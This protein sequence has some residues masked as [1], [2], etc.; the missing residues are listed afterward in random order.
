MYIGTTKVQ[1]FDNEYVLDESG[2]T[3]KIVQVDSLKYSPGLL[4]I[5]VE[6]LSN[7]IDNVWRSNESGVKCTKIKVNINEETGESSVWNDGLWI[8]VELNEGT[9]M[10]NPELIFGNL[11]TSSNYD[12]DEE[13]LTSG[14]NGM[15]VKLTNVF[16]NE[17]YIEVY[18]PEKKMLYRQK[19]TNHMKDKGAHKLKE[20]EREEGGYTYVRWKPDFELFKCAKYSKEILG[21]FYKYV[22]DTAMI[23]GVDVYLNGKRIPVKNLGDYVKFY[24]VGSE[25]YFIS[26]RTCNVYITPSNSGQF[27][28]VAF[29][30]GVYNKDGGI[31]VQMWSDAIFK[32]LL[33]KIRTMKNASFITLKDVTKYFKLFINSK[34]V[35]PEFDSQ[36]KTRLISPKVIANM[37]D[38]GIRKI[39][40]WSFMEDIKDMI[41]Q[42]DMSILKK[43]SKGKTSSIEGLDPANNA[44]TADAGKCTLIL[45]EG[46]S[47]K[48]YAVLGIET[49]IGRLKGRDWYGIYAMRGKCLNARN[50]NPTNIAKNK[51]II[52]IIKAIGLKYDVDYTKDSNFKKLSYGK[53]MILADSDNDGI[54]IAGLVMNFLHFLYPTLFGREEPFLISMQTPIVK[55]N[56]RSEELTFY[57]EEN[58]I[59]FL[60]ENSDTQRMKI[61]YYKGLGTS[62]DK[63]VKNTFGKRILEFT[64]DPD[65]FDSMDKVFNNKM[66]DERKMWLARYDVQYRIPETTDVF[67]EMSISN[68]LDHDMIKFSIDDCKRSI[69]NLYD[70]LKQSQRKILYATCLKN[71]RHS[72]K[73]MKVAQL[74]GFVAEK[75]NYHHGEQ[76]LNETITKMAQDFPGANNVPYLQKDGQF[77]S[78]LSNG[79][80]AASARYIFTKLHK[81]TRMVFRE[82]DDNL[83]EKVVDDGDI[84]EP[85]NYLPIIPMILVNG[86]VGIGTGWSSYIPC[87]NPRDVVNRVKSWISGEEIPDLTPWYSN[88]KGKIVKD[89]EKFFSYGIVEDKKLLTNVLELPVGLSTDKFK[90]FLDTIVDAKKVKGYKNYSTPTDVKFVINRGRDGITCSTKNLKLTT[91]ISTSNMV[92]FD[93][94]GKLKKYKDTTEII[95][96]F[97]EKR[98]ELYVTRKDNMLVNIK[99]MYNIA[100]NKKR[101]LEEVMSDKLTIHKRDEDDLVKELEEREY[102]KVDDKFD[103]LLGMHIRS[104]TKQRIEN[105]GNEV[106]KLKGD[107]GNLKKLDVKD[108]WIMELDEFVK[109]L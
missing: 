36:S 42:K 74:A 78:R 39:M 51:E 83:L 104:F 27:E 86:C 102:K 21:M 25:K 91:S 63:E 95:T 10:Y 94:N 4:R 105:L 75:T 90:E 67:S 17:F 26:S 87:Y 33:Q 30:N 34:I 76:C 99:H 107:Y 1:K 108:M 19:W 5:F 12:D 60:R 109:N 44:G 13:R 56:M 92:L 38:A 98:L 57:R 64:Q 2:E 9:G 103:Y 82:E 61:K 40:K 15:G 71:L 80:D 68:F 7:A 23:S 50:A 72:G 73:S 41:L 48:T 49:G 35:N 93:E 101:F 77:G 66:S 3:P 37:D 58:F 46:L 88:H 6:A 55:I 29:T 54:H 85:H 22:Y 31:H 100:K 70:G 16:S 53:V 11:H 81:L 69:P 59:D 52:S 8:P 62:S 79:K 106:D 18:D 14:R 28:H 20:M 43:T 47:A 97:C 24:N 32:P 84:V 45:C 65:A 89:G 96:K